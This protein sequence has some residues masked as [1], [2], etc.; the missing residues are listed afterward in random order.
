MFLQRPRPWPPKANGFN[1]FGD[2]VL[3]SQELDPLFTVRRNPKPAS[4]PGEAIRTE[5]IID[6]RTT[7]TV[8]G[9]GGGTEAL[10]GGLLAQ[11]TNMGTHSR[12]R[13]TVMPE[14]FLGVSARFN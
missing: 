10:A 8:P 14:A 11:T 12:N 7:N 3:Q 9:S 6:G 1:C 4:D 5:V 13:F 2:D